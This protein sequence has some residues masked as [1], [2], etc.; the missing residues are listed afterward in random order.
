MT[1]L[2][3]A[4]NHSTDPLT[5]QDAEAARQ[6]RLQIRCALFNIIDALERLDNITPR[7]AEL[8]KDYREGKVIRQT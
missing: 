6:C 3:P 8:R 2:N 4:G 7:N 1:T 5:A